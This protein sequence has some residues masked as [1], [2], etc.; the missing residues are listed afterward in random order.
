MEVLEGLKV[1]DFSQAIFG[2]LTGRLLGDEGADVTKVEPL[3]G[4][5]SRL[6]HLREGDSVTFFANNRSKRSIALNL[7]DSRG[8][9]VALKLVRNADVVL[10]NFRPGVMETFGLDYEAV[11]QMNPRVVYGSFYMYGETGPLSRRRGGDPQAQAFTGLVASIGDPG[12]PPHLAGH[13]FIDVAGAALNAFAIVTALLVREKT[14]MGQEVTNNLVNTGCFLQQA[15]ISHYLGDGV[16]FT[17]GGRGN[18]Q[19]QFPYGAYTASDGDVMTIFG[20]DDAEWP[21]VCSILGIDRLATDDRYNSTEKRRELRFELYPILDE[22]FRKKTRAEWEESFRAAGLRCDACLDYRELVEH[23]QF[24]ANE[25]E[26]VVEHSFE[27]PLRM[28]NK[29]I[30]FK[31]EGYT[32]K[33]RSPPVLGEHSMEICRALG[34][35]DQETKQFS[36]EG[37]IGVPTSDMLQPR[38]R[39]TGFH[40]TPLG[41]AGQQRRA[42]LKNRATP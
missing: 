40:P 26:V 2:A 3:E 41:R 14:G 28:L 13:A 16:L 29:P 22:A 19:G 21:V 15:A 37:V 25:L 1:V 24:H 33:F 18:Y 34:Y 10:Q 31:G 11:R 20:Q 35:S 12:G 36:E 38:R 32:Q 27:G 4:D 23:P 42:Q 39:N 17:K 9:E 7:K 8:R 5:M 6:T 30:R